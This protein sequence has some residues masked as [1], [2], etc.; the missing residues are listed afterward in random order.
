MKWDEEPCPPYGVEQQIVF[1]RV[2]DTNDSERNDGDSSPR[3]V[4]KQLKK[5]A[6]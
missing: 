2:D 4:Q 1:R 3:I 6:I 5:M